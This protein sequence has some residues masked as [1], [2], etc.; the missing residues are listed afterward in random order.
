MFHG[1]PSEDPI[2]H[3]DEFDR[4]CDLT[5]INGVSEDAIK[6]RLF[7]MSLADKAHQWE[8]SLPHGTIT[9]WD[10]CK[11]AFLA[12]FFSTG[13][14]AKLRGEISSFIQ[15][16]NETFAE[17][18][19][20]FKGYTSQCPH[21]GFNNESLLS[22]LYRGCLPRY[23][24]MLDTASNGN[25]LNQDVDDGWQLV[26]NMAISKECY[27]EQ[28]DSR[29]SSTATRSSWSSDEKRHACTQLRIKDQE[30][31]E[32]TQEVCYIQNRQGS[33]RNP[34]QGR[35]NN[36]QAPWP[37]LQQSVPQGFNTRTT[38]TQPTQ[39]W[40]M[41][42]MLQQLLQGQ[43]KVGNSSRG[44]PPQIAVDIDDEEGEDLVEYA[45]NSTRTRSSWNKTLNQNSIELKKPRHCKTN[46][47]SIEPEETDKASSSQPAKPVAKKKD[48]PAGPPPYK[49]P[50]P[51]P[52]RF[53][54]QLLEAHK[55]KFDELMRQL[56]LKLPFIDALMLIPPYQ[57]FLK[58]AVQQRTR[59]AQGMVVLT[60]E[61]S[62]IIQRKVISD[63]KEDPGSFTLPCMLGP[64][65]FKNSLCDLGSSVSLMPLSVAKRLGYH[66]YQACGISLV[67]ADR[68]I[69]LPTGML[70]D[71]PLRIGNV[72]IPTD[73]IV[74]EM[75]EEPTDPLI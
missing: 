43:A 18:W 13:R 55:A 24:E 30:G 48:T 68:S 2:D 34:Q 46:Q 16:N 4:L 25:F 49:P 66:K 17:A 3:L 23:R 8:K 72:E 31:E 73:F 33:Y 7:P 32:T 37:H 44:S 35:Y 6:L 57:K 29:W 60:R 5:K 54:K 56:E 14:T 50:L 61:C 45:D 27:G 42:E 40:D 21:H 39:D 20:R 12:K 11:K 38:H 19:E 9:T 10:E 22:T 75:D 1:L 62:A 70:E 64:L 59:E 15:R 69:R 58:D 52:G 67:L 36:Y 53:K 63:K 41:K 65:S 28:Y 74:L 26:E 47:S 71:L 51:F